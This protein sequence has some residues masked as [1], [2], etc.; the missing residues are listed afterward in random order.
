MA[1]LMPALAMAATSAMARPETEEDR[2]GRRAEAVQRAAERRESAKS[3][4]RHST[5][6]RPARDPHPLDAE[7][8]RLAAEKRARKA[9]KAL[10]R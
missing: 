7:R 9:R 4:P 8:L 1:F 10:A 5:D 3:S 2:E 6:E